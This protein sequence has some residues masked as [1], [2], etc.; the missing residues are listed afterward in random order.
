MAR[1]KEYREA[2]ADE[3]NSVA[4]YFR[5]RAIEC[6]ERGEK[7]TNVSTATFGET[8]L[9]SLMHLFSLLYFL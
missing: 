7:G 1:L 5:E 4:A 8:V 6:K 9:H 2:N 3:D